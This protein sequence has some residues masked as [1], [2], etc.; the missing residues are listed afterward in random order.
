MEAPPPQSPDD[1]R[2]DDHSDWRMI[3][4]RGARIF[5]TRLKGDDGGPG[6]PP[7]SRR[8]TQSAAPKK[9]GP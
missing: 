7:A 5:S 3:R 6:A 4:G 1:E 8:R 2:P 9:Y